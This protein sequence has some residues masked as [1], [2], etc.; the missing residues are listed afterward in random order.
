MKGWV[1]LLVLLVAGCAARPDAPLS[2]A[3]VLA[4][5][6]LAKQQYR[7]KVHTELG[8]GYFRRGQH[9]IA[10]QELDEAVAA[11]PRYGPAY[12]VRGLIHMQIQRPVQ[13]RADFERALALNPQDSEA[14]NNYGWF[15]CGQGEYALSLAHFNAALKDPL[16]ATPALAALN[17][18]TCARKAGNAGAAASYLERALRAP[19]PPA[20][21]WLE[22][23]EQSY[24]QAQYAEARQ[25]LAQYA[26]VAN[27][28]AQSLWLGVRLE[29]A[30]RDEKAQASYASQLTRQFP[31][32]TEAARLR[33]GQY[34]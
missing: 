4:R 1:A 9:K 3:E 21:A 12:N 2:E 28:S 5:Q 8:A 27:P 24:A 25:W 7:A 16:Y 19:A 34:Q 17:A 13:A 18:A 22:K 30:L 32:S 26:R 15:L 20:G 31:E 29:R 33:A 23:A 10:L 6:E 14:R 11:D